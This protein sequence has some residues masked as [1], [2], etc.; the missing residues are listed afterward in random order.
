M[1]Y[2]EC[3]SSCPR[4][5]H[6]PLSTT[7]QCQAQNNECTPGCVCSNETVYNS[8]QGECIPLEQCTCQ[9]NNLQYQPGDQVSIDCNDW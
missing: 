2:V 3:A 9:Y 8:I 4:T 6:N 7:T 1:V 5:C